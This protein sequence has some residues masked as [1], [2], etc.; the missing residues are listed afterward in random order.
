ALAGALIAAAIAAAWLVA[1][2]FVRRLE[3]IAAV[4]DRV[5]HGD[6]SA[7][8]LEPGAHDEVGRLTTG[9]NTMLEQV[10]TEQTRLA[11]LVE[12]RTA[13]LSASREHFRQIVE[14]TR[15][16][17]FEYSRQEKRFTYVG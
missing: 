6:L 15:A 10:R 14:T 16:I 17:P 2:L 7:E 11:S 9:F 4:A 1:G 5:A 8:P 12:G 13:E 3:R